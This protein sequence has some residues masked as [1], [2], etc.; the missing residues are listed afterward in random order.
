[1]SSLI[2]QTTM[3]ALK[4]LPATHLPEALRKTSYFRTLD[5]IENFRLNIVLTK[6]ADTKNPIID[7]RT[8]Y[9]N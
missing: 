6:I 1:M 3:P 5:P 4:P 8:I 7:H 9:L 2:G